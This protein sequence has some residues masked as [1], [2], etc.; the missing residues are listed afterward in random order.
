MMLKVNPVPSVIP[1]TTIFPA[2][3]VAGLSPPTV[4]EE[5]VKV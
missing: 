1:L 3:V 2:A 5:G 4:P